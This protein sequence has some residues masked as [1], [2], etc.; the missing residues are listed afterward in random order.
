MKKYG[1]ILLLNSLCTTAYSSHPRDEAGQPKRSSRYYPESIRELDDMMFSF[2]EQQGKPV[3]PSPTAVAAAAASQV[4]A[5]APQ[6][7]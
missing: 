4:T 1:W 2:A 3:P 5:P 7:K 6:Q